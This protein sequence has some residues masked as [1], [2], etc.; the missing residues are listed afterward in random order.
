[1]SRMFTNGISYGLKKVYGIGPRALT[2][3]WRVPPKRLRRSRQSLTALGRSEPPSAR[4]LR[5]Q[6]A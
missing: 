1:M 4:S 3:A 6:S 2:K 5:A